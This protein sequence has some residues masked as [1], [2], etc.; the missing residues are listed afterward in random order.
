MSRLRSNY[1]Y[2]CDLFFIFI[3]IFVMINCI[4]SGV[5]ANLFFCLIFR[6]LEFIWMMTLKNVNNFQMAKV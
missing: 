5:Q 4:I 6:I 3:F 1:A 2:I